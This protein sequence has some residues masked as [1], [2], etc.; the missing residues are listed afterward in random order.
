MGLGSQVHAGHWILHPGAVP[1][2][3]AVPG[4]QLLLPRGAKLG[5]GRWVWRTLAS[6]MMMIMMLS[7]LPER[8]WRPWPEAAEQ[9][10]FTLSYRRDRGLEGS[11]SLPC[12]LSLVLCSS[13]TLR[14]VSPISSVKII[15]KSQ[16]KLG[17]KDTSIAS[18]HKE[19]SAQA[20]EKLS[21][22]RQA[23]YGLTYTWN[24]KQKQKQNDRKRDQVS[25]RKVRG[26]I[27]G[28]WSKGANFQ[29]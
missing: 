3:T 17:N 22:E 8:S 28:R 18:A 19:A 12:R 15:P 7:A 13:H 21:R 2:H 6:R 16:K 11:S 9:T 27:R 29:V 5:L 4:M 24:L 23:L 20:S 26:D 10:E 14:P 1:V 25:Q